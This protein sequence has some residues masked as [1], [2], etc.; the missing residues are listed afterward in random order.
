MKRDDIEEVVGKTFQPA[1]F[2]EVVVVGVKNAIA[3][4]GFGRAVLRL[5]A[6]QSVLG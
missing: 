6:W 3:Q 5:D 1:V 4:A 2:G